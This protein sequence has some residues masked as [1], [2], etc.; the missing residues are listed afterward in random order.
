[1]LPS[2]SDDHRNEEIFT[3]RKNRHLHHK[4]VARL[5]AGVMYHLPK[6]PTQ[7]NLLTILETVC[8]RPI[9]AQDFVDQLVLD[10]GNRP[11]S[12]RI[13]ML[14]LMPFTWNHCFEKLK[15]GD[16]VDAWNKLVETAQ[17]RIRVLCG[18]DDYRAETPVPEDR[19]E[20]YIFEHFY[21]Q[22]QEE[23]EAHGWHIRWARSAFVCCCISFLV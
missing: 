16:Q 5:L 23:I 1:M 13:W 7:D 22:V 4:Y 11:N 3:N 8:E 20:Q 19:Q 21:R 9:Q 14:F 18:H 15:S 2:A 10:T 17:D 12:F 6:T